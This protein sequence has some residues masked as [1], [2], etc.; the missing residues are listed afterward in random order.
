MRRLASS[1]GLVALAAIGI[2]AGALTPLGTAGRVVG[3]GPTTIT[4]TAKEFSF[5]LSKKTVPVGTTVA[6]KVVNKGKISHNFSIAGKVTKMLSPGQTATLT[7]RFAKKG[8]VAYLCTLT[9]H[10]GAGMSH[11]TCRRRIIPLSI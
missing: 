2:I 10:A 8:L 11:R 7:V 3:H 4:V 5:A 1:S 6:F 9:G